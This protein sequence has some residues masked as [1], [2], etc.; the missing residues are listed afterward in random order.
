MP[1]SLPR[2]ISLGIAAGVV[3]GMFGVGGGIVVVPGLVL[4]LRFGQHRAS[5]TSVAT[6]GPLPWYQLAQWPGQQSVRDISIA[7]QNKS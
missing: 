3:G 2:A 6:G 7:F 1:V 5:G 4:W